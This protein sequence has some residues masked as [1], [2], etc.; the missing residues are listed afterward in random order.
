MHFERILKENFVIFVELVIWSPLSDFSSLPFFF[1]F[2]RESL[3]EFFFV[4]FGK[5]VVLILF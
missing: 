3:V 5:N 2:L 4:D 1:D